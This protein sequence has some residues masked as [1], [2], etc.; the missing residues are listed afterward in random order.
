MILNEDFSYIVSLF[1]FLKK[2]IINRFFLQVRL[3]AS[4]A[5]H[6]QNTIK[7]MSR[8]PGFVK[9]IISGL[10]FYYGCLVLFSYIVEF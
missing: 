9:K 4:N 5:L 10:P 2:I 8:N 7:I 6:T 3:F 1:L